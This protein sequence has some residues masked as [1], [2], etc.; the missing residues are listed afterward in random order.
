MSG[1]SSSTDCPNCSKEA[2]LYQDWKPF[3]YFYISCPYCGLQI[4]PLVTYMTLE[5]L[6]EERQ[7][8]YNME[9]LTELPDQSFKF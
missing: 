4:N 1:C 6:N 9:P 8:C 2:N 7:D 3:D 5:E